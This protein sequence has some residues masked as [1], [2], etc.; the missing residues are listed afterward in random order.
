[1]GVAGEISQHLL[2][3]AEWSL[4][5][6]HPFTVAQGCQEGGEGLCVDQGRR[7]C[8]HARMRD[9]NGVTMRY[10]VRLWLGCKLRGFDLPLAEIASQIR[11]KDPGEDVVMDGGSR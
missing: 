4:S 6:D 7:R 1:M 5:I 8:W 9:V 3:A 10:P 2:G 11:L